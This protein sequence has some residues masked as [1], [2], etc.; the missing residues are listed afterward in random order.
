MKDFRARFAANGVARAAVKYCLVV[1]LIATIVMGAV[2][3]VDFTILSKFV[4]PPH[5]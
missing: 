5:S 3:A 2:A 1:A 4:T